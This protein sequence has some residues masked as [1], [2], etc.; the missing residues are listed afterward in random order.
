MA[1]RYLSDDD[2]RI[3]QETINEVADT[4]G[5]RIVR[6]VRKGRNQ[7]AGGFGFS[8]YDF[9]SNYSDGVVTIAPGNIV[10]G[11][12]SNQTVESS[13]TLDLQAP[14]VHYVYIEIRWQQVIF[15]GEWI[16]FFGETVGNRPDQEPG[17]GVLVPVYRKVIAK[18]TVVDELVTAFTPNHI[19]EIDIP[20][21]T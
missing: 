21:I 2:A 5:G 1:K 6:G 11:L 8:G 10:G 19:G 15:D 20:R 3:V 4:P 13:V 14:G 16:Y 7:A 17:E 12:T 9:E 18:A